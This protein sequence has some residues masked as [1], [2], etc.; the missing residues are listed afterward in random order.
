[1]G[2]TEKLAVLLC[3]GFT[4]TIS[5][6]WAVILSAPS[7]WSK[8]VSAV[9]ALDV[10]LY[11]VEIGNG[12]VQH[13]AGSFVKSMSPKAEKKLNG[14]TKGTLGLQ[15]FA[16]Y[17]CQ[18]RL[19]SLLMTATNPCEVASRLQWSSWLMLVCGL[20]GTVALATGG[21]G[22]YYWSYVQAR[23][24]VRNSTKGMFCLATAFYVTGTLQYIF[25]ASDLDQLPPQTNGTTLGVCAM[26]AAL[27]TVASFV[28]LYTS[29]RVVTQ[30]LEELSIERD[31]EQKKLL[32][33]LGMEGMPYGAT[34]AAKLQQGD[35]YFPPP[36]GCG[37]PPA[38]GELQAMPG[39]GYSPY[40][41]E[42]PPTAPMGPAGAAPPVWC[43]PSSVGNTM[44]AVG[45]PAAPGDPFLMAGNSY[46]TGP[47]PGFAPSEAPGMPGNA[48]PAQGAL[49]AAGP[50]FAPQ[51]YAHG[52]GQAGPLAG[53]FAT[54]AAA[55]EG[56]AGTEPQGHMQQF[57]PEQA[58]GAAPEEQSPQG[59]PPQQM[60]PGGPAAMSQP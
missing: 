56:A 23:K 24:V 49:G 51:N 11:Q 8:K 2:P 19:D 21:G 59:M 55:P 54:G 52:P 37:Q 33:E 35:P 17:L 14:F 50:G 60:L 36:Q 45:G 3:L 31:H 26:T 10:G 7:G 4:S 27:L 5:V 32:R 12:V 15:E 22:L 47:A 29:V 46:A 6:I 30:T 44:P 13:V 38:F 16:S 28:P 57:P 42:P 43:F 1:M 53:G 34:D 41:A 39:P 48:A 40:S 25:V 58:M 18:M 9:Y 20:M